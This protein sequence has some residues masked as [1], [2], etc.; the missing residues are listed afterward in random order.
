MLEL[1]IVDA[2]ERIETARGCLA[3]RHGGYG[4]LTLVV[5]ACVG[6]SGCS[7]PQADS[8]AEPTPVASTSSSP[9]AEGEVDGLVDVGGRRKIVARCTSAGSPTL[10]LEGGD[11][12]TSASYTFAVPS[13]EEVTRTCFYDRANFGS[14]DPAPGPR[15]LPELVADLEKAISAAEIPGPYIR[16]GTSGGGYITAGYAFANPGQ[17]AGMVF[18]EV[19]SPFRDPPAPIVR[20]TR[21]SPAAV[22]GLGPGDGR[23]RVTRTHHRDYAARGHVRSA[24]RRWSRRSEAGGRSRRPSSSGPAPAGPVAGSRGSSPPRRGERSTAA[25]RPGPTRGRCGLPASTFRPA[26]TLS[27]TRWLRR[28]WPMGRSRCG[29]RARSSGTPAPG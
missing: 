12:D 28:C 16:V 11:G 26:S 3:K 20:D 8:S 22:S 18:V 15:G 10:V 7:D 27:G 24:L 5:F 23:G 17:V 9:T 14:S 2:V 13:L 21:R 29:R 25:A 4:A 6:L 1:T 19:P